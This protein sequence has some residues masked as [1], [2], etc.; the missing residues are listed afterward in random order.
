MRE[1]LLFHGNA[2]TKEEARERCRSII[3]RDGL[4]T[5]AGWKIPSSV[6]RRTEK[7]YR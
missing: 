7:A 5:G 2:K 3:A 1:P 6:L 4:K